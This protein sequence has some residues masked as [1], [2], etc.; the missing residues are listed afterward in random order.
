MKANREVF[1]K[2]LDDMF[3]CCPDFDADRKKINDKPREVKL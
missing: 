2:A 1:K 3:G